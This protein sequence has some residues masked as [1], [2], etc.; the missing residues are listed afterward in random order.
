L[1][2]PELFFAVITLATQEK[3]PMKNHRRLLMTEKV[4]PI[5]V[6]G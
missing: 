2:I 5:A 6:N 1:D 3:T 4:L